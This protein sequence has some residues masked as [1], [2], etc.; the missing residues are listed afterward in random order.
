ML[1]DDEREIRRRAVRNALAEHLLSH[2]F[3]P[4]DELRELLDRFSRGEITIEQAI[5]QV[6]ARHSLLSADAASAGSS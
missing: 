5:D 3:P 6:K 4:S 1:D 2:N